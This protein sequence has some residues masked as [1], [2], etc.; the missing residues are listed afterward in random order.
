M[1]CDEGPI[2]AQYQSAQKISLQTGR[3]REGRS[4]LYYRTAGR[5]KQKPARSEVDR[6]TSSSS[7]IYSPISENP[8]LSHVCQS[9]GRP[10]PAVWPGSESKGTIMLGSNK[11]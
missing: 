1:Q 8:W 10:M 2:S 3:V 9:A 11:G 5:R 7:L 4:A 6:G